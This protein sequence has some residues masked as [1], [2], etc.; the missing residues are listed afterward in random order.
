MKK[1]MIV[2]MIMA[3]AALLITTVE[4]GVHREKHVMSANGRR[5]H[6]HVHSRGTTCV[7]AACMSYV[8]VPRVRTYYTYSVVNVPTV[9][10]RAVSVPVCTCGPSCPCAAAAAAAATAAPAA[11]K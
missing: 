5:I 11:P 1:L 9:S 2:G 3:C 7:G 8:S 6:S 4:A 10:L